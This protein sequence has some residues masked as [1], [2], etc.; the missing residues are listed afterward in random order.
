M[1]HLHKGTFT[2]VSK[3]LL[4]EHIKGLSTDLKKAV[5]EIGNAAGE[6]LVEGNNEPMKKAL[7]NYEREVEKINNLGKLYD[8]KTL[9]LISLVCSDEMNQ[10]RQIIENVDP[11]F[12]REECGIK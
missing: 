3:D 12:I 5:E 10:I 1:I 8:Q 4:I 2:K 6:A 7:E 9:V 11:D